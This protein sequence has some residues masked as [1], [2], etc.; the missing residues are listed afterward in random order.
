MTLETKGMGD[1][2]EQVKNFLKKKHKFKNP[3][4]KPSKKHMLKK[5]GKV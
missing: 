1:I 3:P 4:Y 5:G 2:M